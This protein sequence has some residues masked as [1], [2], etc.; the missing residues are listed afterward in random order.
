MIIAIQMKVEHLVVI[1]DY[2]LIINHIK[3]KYKERMEKMKCY[4]KRVKKLMDCFK[5]FNISFIPREKI[6]KM[7]H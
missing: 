3:G 2:E 6:K 5:Y 1:N 4:I 7:M